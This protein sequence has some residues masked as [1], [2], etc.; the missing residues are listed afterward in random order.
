MNTN[1]SAADIFKLHEAFVREYPQWL[2]GRPPTYQLSEFEDA[3]PIAITV[4]YGQNREICS[5]QPPPDHEPQER[6][7]TDARLWLEATDFTKILRMSMAY[8]TQSR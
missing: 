2:A 3:V 8:A 7:D 1:F 6:I 4:K 5:L